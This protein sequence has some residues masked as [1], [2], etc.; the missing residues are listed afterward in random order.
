MGD[1]VGRFVTYVPTIRYDH[2]AGQS[3]AHS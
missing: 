1:S 2:K 3:H